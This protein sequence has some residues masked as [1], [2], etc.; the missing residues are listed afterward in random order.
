MARETSTKRCTSSTSNPTGNR[1]EITVQQE[2]LMKADSHYSISF[3]TQPLTIG[4]FSVSGGY[5]GR[6]GQLCGKRLQRTKESENSSAEEYKTL[7]NNG[8]SADHK[9]L[10]LFHFDKSDVLDVHFSWEIKYYGTALTIGFDFDNDNK[11]SHGPYQ[12]CSLQNARETR[13]LQNAC[14]AN[15]K[16]FDSWVRDYATSGDIYN[17]FQ[18]CSGVLNQQRTKTVIKF[19][20]CYNFCGAGQYRHGCEV[21]GLDG[22]LDRGCKIDC[23]PEDKLERVSTLKN[24]LDEGTV[25]KVISITEGTTSIQTSQTGGSSSTSISAKI[26][27][28]LKKVF[29]A[30]L[31]VSHTTEYNWAQS[32]SSSFSREVRNEARIPVEPKKEVK[33]RTGLTAMGMSTFVLLIAVISSHG[34]YHCEASQKEARTNEELNSSGSWDKEDKKEQEDEHDGLRAMAEEPEEIHDESNQNT[35]QGSKQGEIPKKRQNTHREKSRERTLEYKTKNQDSIKKIA[36]YWSPA[37]GALLPEPYHRSTATG[38]LPK[39]PCYQ[40]P[41]PELYYTSPTT[42]GALLQEPYYRSP[43]TGALLQVPCYRSPATGALLQEPCYR[44]CPATGALLQEPCYSSPATGVLLQ[45]PCYR[46]STTRALLQEVPCYRSPTTGGALVQEP[47]YR[48]CPAGTGALLQEVPWYRSPT[49]GGALV[50]EPYY[51]RC[52]ATGA[53]LQEPCYR[54]PATGALLQEPCYRSPATGALL[55]EPCYRSPTTGA[56]L[57]E[58]CYRSPATGALLQEPYHRSPATGALLQEPR[59]NK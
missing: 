47:Y 43:A 23:T 17:K 40:S 42:G 53:L 37:T 46:S 9:K 18:P 1:G 28:T 11:N 36:C 21:E 49:T 4:S 13:N 45:K 2:I 7:H 48:R 39:E 59:L 41:L 20:Y 30:E 25:T 32:S 3:K 58:P 56:L 14:S 51:R 16:N 15:G 5:K 31:G 12:D 6:P 8:G 27:I 54:S 52:P 50:Q 44:S 57:Q 29:S 10:S 38:A 55:Q 22:R 34:A 33:Q 26:G 24:E 35:P 19:C